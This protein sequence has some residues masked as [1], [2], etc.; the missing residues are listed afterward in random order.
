MTA[1]DDALLRQN[2]NPRDAHPP[3]DRRRDRRLAP[4]LALAWSLAY[5]SLAV[6]HL[7]GRGFAPWTPTEASVLGSLGA[8]AVSVAIMV[9][10]ATALA[11]L[12]LSV[13]DRPD[14]AHPVG[15]ARGR[16]VGGRLGPVLLVV[17]GLLVALT[18]ADTR[19]LTFLGYLPMVLLGLVGVGPADDVDPAL[20]GPALLAMGQ[21]VGGLAL[22]VTGLTAVTARRPGS[23]AWSSERAARLGRW[24][25]AVAVAVPLFYASTRVAW[26]LGVPF[27]VRDVFLDELGDARYAGLGLALFGLVGCLLTLGLVQ[28]WGEVFWSWVPGIGGRPV[29][30]GLAVVPATFVASLVTS[31]GLSFLRLLAVGELSRIPGSE[32]DWAAWAP[33]MFWPLWGVALGVAAL[34]YRARRHADEQVTT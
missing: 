26:A 31:A 34:A 16:T 19:S 23:E 33:E 12:A 30:V 27:G 1:L 14:R 3:S 21:S 2:P 7:V 10:A 24:A 15:D 6:L 22:V 29:P 32:A 8:R 4:L 18:L 5:L 11:A 13:P 25:A 20:L 9:L 28:R 17:V